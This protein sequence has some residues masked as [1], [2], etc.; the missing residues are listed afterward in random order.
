[1]GACNF[2]IPVKL[3]H[4]KKGSEMVIACAP[5]GYIMNSENFSHLFVEKNPHVHVSNTDI[6]FDLSPLSRLR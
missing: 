5:F 1:M 4:E 6:Q 3:D 2:P